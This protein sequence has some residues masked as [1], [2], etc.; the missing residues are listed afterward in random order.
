MSNPIQRIT[1]ATYD[2]TIEANVPGYTAPVNTVT[3]ALCA[4]STEDAVEGSETT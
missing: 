2:F 3:G 4:P 1:L